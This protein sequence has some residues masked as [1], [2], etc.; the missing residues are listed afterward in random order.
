MINK[1]EGAINYIEGV[2]SYLNFLI[3]DYNN[4][5]QSIPSKET[6]TS[7]K[8]A[9]ISN[10]FLSIKE[11]LVENVGNLCFSS[12]LLN[13]YLEENV[14]MIAKK[15]NQGYLADKYLFPSAGNLVAIIRNK[16]AHGKYLINYE[17]N[18]IEI[19]HDNQT[20]K[21]D[22]NKLV[23]MVVIGF[24]NSIS[25]IKTNEY[26]RSIIYSD[27]ISLKREK[28]L[29][30][31]SEIKGLV[32]SFKNIKFTI[33]SK[34]GSD[35]DEYTI[36]MFK[37]L[38]DNFGYIHTRSKLLNAFESG[39]KQNGYELIK[40]NSSIKENEIDEIVDLIIARDNDYIKTFEEQYKMIAII[41]QKHLDS[42]YNKLHPLISGINNLF[43]LDH[44]AS[45]KTIKSFK[46]KN[47]DSIQ[48]IGINEIATTAIALFNSL[49]VYSYD[50]IYKNENIYTSNTSLGLDYKSLDISNFKN[51]KYTLDKGPVETFLEQE[52]ALMKSLSNHQ[53]SLKQA[54][55]SLEIVTKKNNQPAINALNTKIN[56]LNL[57]IQK[58]TNALS[59][60]QTRLKEID[61]YCQNNLD[62]L[63]NKAY[64]EGIRNSIA[65]GNYEIIEKYSI[66]NSIII[67]K[68]IYEGN[69]TFQAEISINDFIKFLNDSKNIIMPFLETKKLIK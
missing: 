12:K 42:K 36:N 60:I 18:Y 40:N 27:N 63:K 48:N 25:V 17:D 50:D 52:T 28:K 68:D 54:Q 51:V 57:A 44:L 45:G 2:N 3:N 64:I 33:K 37:L 32:R 56:I 35:I 62:Y 20:I 55:A 41:I 22:I 6:L 30:T 66:N 10:M 38:R 23:N 16:L 43:I 69:L 58:E 7:A 8:L 4:I 14:S 24:R 13:N 34:D 9:I 11:N 19:N 61:D 5:T 47:N 21:I 26:S 31:K 29:K 65:H 39:L 67:F 46:E 59:S 49:F 53:E 1:E 15:T